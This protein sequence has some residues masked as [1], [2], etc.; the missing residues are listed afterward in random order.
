MKKYQQRIRHYV[1]AT[2][3]DGACH[4]SPPPRPH[5]ACIRH[6]QSVTVTVT[7]PVTVTVTVQSPSPSP[8][9]PPPPRFQNWPFAREYVYSAIIYSQCP[10]TIPRRQSH[11]PPVIRHPSH[12]TAP[13][14]TG[15][16]YVLDGMWKT[17][18]FHWKMCTR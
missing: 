3:L 13:P 1:T 16:K 7:V 6:H 18:R 2:S 9:P 4:P 10:P 8:S 12:C 17:G 15:F 11:P 5:L 14:P